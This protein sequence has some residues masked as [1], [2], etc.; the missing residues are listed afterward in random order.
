VIVSSPTGSTAYSL[1]AGG[2][3]L[4]PNIDAIIITPICAHTL[5]TR[6]IVISANETVEIETTGPANLMS[7][8][9][10]QIPVLDN[11]IVKKST[12]NAKF[13]RFKRKNFYT[14]LKD[15]LIDWNQN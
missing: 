11:V 8:G 4:S 3:I 6:P 15:K 9:Y 13:I 7:D 10:G 1:S 5:H 12:L 2:P 14:L